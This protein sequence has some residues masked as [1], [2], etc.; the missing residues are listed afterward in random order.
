MS[1]AAAIALV[2]TTIGG[3]LTHPSTVHAAT[4]QVDSGVIGWD[5]DKDAAVAH[6]DGSFDIRAGKNITVGFGIYDNPASMQWSNAGGYYPALVTSFQR[7]NTTVTITNFGDKVTIHGRAYV[8]VYSRVSVYNHDSVAHVEDP[9]PSSQL[10]PLNS[11]PTT[12]NPGQTVNHDYVIAVDEFGGSYPWPANADLVA[13]GCYNS[14]Y[15]H[16]TSYWDARL[17]GIAQINVPDPRLVNAYKAGY[18]YTNI[19]KDG[20]NL[21]VGENGY[22]QLFDHDVIGI[23]TNLLTEGDLA[24]AHAYLA[25]LSGPFTST[26]Y[27]D[28]TYKYSWP[29]AVY[30]EKSG[31]AAFVSANFSTIKANAH[32]IAT[33]ATGPGGTMMS[34][35]AID[36]DGHWTVDDESALTGLLAYQYIAAKLGN[37]AEATWAANEYSTLFSAVN[38][39]IQSTINANGLSYLPCAI[40][41]PNTSN[42][43][44]YP[45]DANWAST[46]LFGRWNWDGYLFGANRTGPLATMLDATYDYGFAHLT[47][48]PPHTYGGY[49]GYSTAYNAGYG[50]AGLSSTGHRSEGIYDYQFMINNTQSAPFS[51]WEGIP[52][53]GTTAWGPG[54]HATAGTGSSPHMWGQANASHVLLDSLMA[55]KSDGQVIVGRGVPDEWLRSGQTVS[56][57][58][59]PITGGKRI[60]ATVSTSGNAVTL[61]LSGAAP[62]AGVAFEIPDFVGN[63]ASASAGTVDNANGIVTLPSGTTSVT[64]TLSTVPAFQQIGGLDLTSYCKSIGD[65]GGASLDGTT[66][67]DW[68]C[69]T[70]SGTHVSMDMNDA[71][72]WGNLY[73]PSAFAQAGSPSDPNSWSCWSTAPVPYVPPTGPVTGYA[74]L[75]LDV[76]GGNTADRTPVQVYTCNYTASQSWTVASDSALQAFGKCLDVRDGNTANGTAVQLYTCNTTASQVW[77][78]SGG[79]LL[80]PLSGRCLTDPGSGGSG[81]SLQIQDCVAGT[82]NQQWTLPK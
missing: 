65:I 18:I 34:S 7:D 82:A 79:Q 78:Q 56:A 50:E 38:T 17:A 40:D 42:R 58:N 25:T 43:C 66:A 69:V 11:A 9:A 8:A 62:A 52:T 24:N 45:N 22:D 81:T 51:W 63:V 10:L 14:H 72:T 64:V 2:A 70:D 41:V 13:A 57:T 26:T 1:V 28:A 36:A 19:V 54:R 49:P 32:Q 39:E 60:G 15:A 29:W 6:A 61:T 35:N 37:S 3:Q 67:N 20:N 75:C 16:M 76:S 27:P 71:C 59:Y 33:D 30:L 68:R 53:A 55:E 5:G 4:N 77:Q 73:N 47:S 74:G 31:D 80:N 21:D 44:S 46:L 12:V 23:L 48:L